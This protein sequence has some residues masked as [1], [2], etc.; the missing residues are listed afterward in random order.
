MAPLRP[1]RCT[2]CSLHGR[3]R[4]EYTLCSITKG[5]YWAYD[6]KAIAHLF[7]NEGLVKHFLEGELTTYISEACRNKT[8][9]LTRPASRRVEASIDPKVPFIFERRSL[10][11]SLYF[12]QCHPT[13]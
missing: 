13:C 9:L 7:E 6:V 10:F 1:C 4:A 8:V 3:R 2:T 12:L 5:R 11:S